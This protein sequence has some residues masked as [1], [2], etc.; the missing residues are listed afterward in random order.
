MGCHDSRAM[1]AFWNFSMTGSECKL[2]ERCS[3][4]SMKVLFEG[5][6]AMLVTTVQSKFDCKWAIVPTV[7]LIT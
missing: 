5:R 3:Q 4:S 1:L 2:H 7:Y 6:L